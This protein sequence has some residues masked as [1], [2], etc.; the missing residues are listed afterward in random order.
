MYIIEQ[1]QTYTVY[2]FIDNLN[3]NAQNCSGL[4]LS[5]IGCQDHM[6]QNEISPYAGRQTR[7]GVL[8]S[9][10]SPSFYY[11][12]QAEVNLAKLA[13]NFTHLLRCR[14]T[15]LYTVFVG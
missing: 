4:Y 1:T 5:F 15:A 9:I 2:I 14:G 6:T 13:D 12:N 8:L 11:V 3:I 10:K 7:L